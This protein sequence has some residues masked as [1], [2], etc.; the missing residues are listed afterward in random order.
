MSEEPKEQWAIVELMG[1]CQT[2]GKISWPGDCGGLL[3]IDVPIDGT[4]RTE[5]Y[6]MAAIYAVKLVSETIAK[7][8]AVRQP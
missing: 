4:Y 2:A 5:Y 7:A 6:G 3:R 8:Y 1:P